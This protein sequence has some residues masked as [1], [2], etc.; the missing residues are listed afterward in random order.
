MAVRKSN[1]KDRVKKL[2]GNIASKE[3]ADLSFFTLEEM[4]NVDLVKV[5][6]PDSHT[7]SSSCLKLRCKCS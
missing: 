1:G 2:V 7:T 3:A 6:S 5:L 4:S